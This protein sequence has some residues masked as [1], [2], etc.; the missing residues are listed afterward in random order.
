VD[1]ATEVVEIGN[2]AVVT[3]AGMV[4]LAGTPAT[5]E[6]LEDRATTAPPCGAALERVTVPW[7]LEPPVTLAGATEMLLSAA[8][9]AAVS[10]T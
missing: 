7:E 5:P 10:V 9:G 8:G 4:T 3:P 2:V 6:L 1:A